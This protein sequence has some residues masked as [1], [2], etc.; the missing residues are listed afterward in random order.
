MAALLILS[1][2]SNCI[3]L[4]NEKEKDHTERLTALGLLGATGQSGVA[5]GGGTAGPSGITLTSSDG[6][7]TIN[8][9]PDAMN[10][11]QEFTITRYTP[12]TG[13]LPGEYFPTT[14]AYEITPSYL[15]LKDVTVSISLDISTIA[16]LNLNQDASQGF[17][18]SSTSPAVGAERFPDW[19]G[20]SSQVDGDRL[21]MSTRTFS[22]FGGG[23]PPGGNL[24]PTILGAFYSFEPSL[25]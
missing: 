9:P 11:E 8:I 13:A 1:A 6:R 20:Q 24:P 15:F 21:T 7:L 4:L 19:Q 2:L 12:A 3:G 5:V 10:D 22:I 16:A 25:S 23:T 17:S 18:S 14:P